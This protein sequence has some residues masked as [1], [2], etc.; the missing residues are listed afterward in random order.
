[1]KV[2]KSLFVLLFFISLASPVNASTNVEMEEYVVS[3]YSDVISITDQIFLNNLS[4]IYQY[5][6][7]DHEGK[8]VL[9]ESI[10]YIIETYGFSTDFGNRLNNI[11]F[12]SN[13]YSSGKMLNTRVFISDW[14]VYLTYSEVMM[15]LFAAAEI[16]PAAITAALTALGSVYPGVGTALGM[17]VGL[18]GAGTIVYYVIQSSVRRQGLYLGIDW[19]GA[20]PNPAIGFW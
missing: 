19:N 10:E 14:K 20:F 16:G 13:I 3:S 6:T 5:F 18:V 12:L 1:M 17:L 11:I 2:L 7:F 8:L 9:S 15:T 4:E